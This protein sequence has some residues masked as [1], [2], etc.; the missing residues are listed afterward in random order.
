[1]SFPN[2]H[3][4]SFTPISFS[5]AFVNK[6]RETKGIANIPSIRTIISIP[7]FIT[8]RYFR[9]EILIPMDYIEAAVYNTPYEDQVIAKKIAHELLF[10]KSLSQSGEAT[11][12]EKKTKTNKPVNAQNL[13]A[14]DLIMSELADLGLNGIDLDDESNLFD[15]L[16]E[17][18]DKSWNFLNNLLNSNETKHQLMLKLLDSLEY[19]YKI[20]EQ[21]IQSMEELNDYLK[22]TLMQ[23]AGSWED[24]DMKYA[25]E[26]NYTDILAKYSILPWEI[27]TSLALTEN[28]ELSNFLKDTLDTSEPTSLGYI[29]RYLT[30]VNNKPDENWI[31]EAFKRVKTLQ[32]YY[33]LIHA[34][35]EYK[36]PEDE[37]LKNSAQHEMKQSL[38]TADEIFTQFA[39][40]LSSELFN[41]WK[42]CYPQPKINDVLDA[43]HPDPSWC[44]ILEDAVKREINTNNPEEMI[45]LARKLNTFSHSRMDTDMISKKNDLVKEVATLAMEHTTTKESF[46]PRL[47]DIFNNSIIPDYPRI[48]KA[49]EGLNISEEEIAE[50]FNNPIEQLR[51]YILSN[52]TQ[53]SKYNRLIPKISGIA[54]P[55]MTEF[56]QHAISTNNSSALGA[57]GAI[58]MGSASQTADEL[59][60]ID[61]LV[62]AIDIR[63]GGGENLIKQWFVHRDRLPK[64]FREKIQDYIR[65]LLV[66]IGIEWAN[67]GFGNTEE[68]IIPKLTI[69]PFREGDDMDLLDI[70]ATLDSILSSGK[71]L[72]FITMD[73]LMI[74]ETA[75]GKAALGVLIDI[76]GSMSGNNLAMCAI[77]V[78]MLL[79]KLDTKEIAI[80]M[81]ESNTHIIKGFN[82]D[83]GLSDV[84][85][86]LLLITARGGTRIDAALQW[87]T[88]E[89]ENVVDSEVRLLYLLSDFCF[90]EKEDYILNLCQPL[91]NETVRILCASHS[92]LNR[93][94]MELMKSNLDGHEMRIKNFDTL[95]KLLS[96]VISSF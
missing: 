76:S 72:R 24:L 85:N 68:G 19:E 11:E 16:S 18:Q 58:D 78:I 65:D 75:K 49:G 63:A 81:F 77:A 91:A 83:I 88:K 94:I 59:G 37:L 22:Q 23:K 93:K 86:E 61:K 89:F 70:D 6:M 54:K 84:A 7:K 74:N 41:H 29:L 25:G 32:G 45:E 57:L 34:T 8:A 90:F 95:P 9:K 21:G 52:N 48:V 42:N 55:K 17:Q 28:N 38:D 47:E 4:Q 73:E 26:L 96:E 40:D 60:A 87:I 82:D 71:E 35:Q 92:Q 53:Q 79:A 46:L 27:A 43:I 20:I 1:M 36:K 69:R 51:M 13:S 50:L 14:V 39:E 64:E 31:S 5:V 3:V 44:N 15:D 67:K 10:P 56:M 33:E 80:A 30:T 2:D 66:E 12:K 62:N